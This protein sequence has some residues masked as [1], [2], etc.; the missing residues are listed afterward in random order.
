MNED[1]YLPIKH[2]TYKKVNTGDILFVEVDDNYSRFFT[3]T[4]NYLLKITLAQVQAILPQENF[5][6]VH[7]AYIINIAKIT[8]IEPDHICLGDKSIPFARQF[9][10]KL[11][12]RL[13]IMK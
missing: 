5:F 9:R 10:Q 8:D 7:R 3:A 12:S 6:R 1:I 4:E 2:K 13:K 11:I